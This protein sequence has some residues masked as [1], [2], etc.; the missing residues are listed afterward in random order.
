MSDV[1]TKR[2]TFRAAI[3]ILVTR[4][5]ALAQP[6]NPGAY[7]GSVR[8]RLLNDKRDHARALME[9]QLLTPERLA[10]LLDDTPE[11]AAPRPTVRYHDEKAGC[12]TCGCYGG[13]GWLQSDDRCPDTGLT[14]DA[15]PCPVCNVDGV[16]DLHHRGNTTD[17]AE[18]HRRYAQGIQHH[19][20]RHE[21]RTA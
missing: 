14:A 21:A 15:E 12:S 1:A 20:E 18:L 19:R 16:R 17:R 7:A 10:E 11:V 9:D 8:S 3:D 4:E 6:N 2:E 5:V 13:G